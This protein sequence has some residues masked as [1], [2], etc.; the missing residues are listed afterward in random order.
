MDYTHRDPMPRDEWEPTKP[1]CPVC[2]GALRVRGTRIDR[3][4]GADW[5]MRYRYRECTACQ[6]RAL[7][8]KEV[9]AK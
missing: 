2:G 7:P 1:V 5:A 3:N 6:W 8:T 9:I 4:T